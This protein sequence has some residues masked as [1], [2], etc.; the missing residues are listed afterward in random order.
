MRDSSS[1]EKACVSMSSSSSCSACSSARGVAQPGGTIEVHHARRS[2]RASDRTRRAHHLTRHEPDLLVTF[3]AHGRRVS[4]SPGLRLPAGSSHAH[5]PSGWRYCRTRIISPRLRDRHDHHRARMPDDLGVAACRPWAANRLDLDG[6]D[7]PFVDWC[8][9]LWDDRGCSYLLVQS[10]PARQIRPSHRRA[11]SAGS[12]AT[13][14]IR[15]SSRGW[16]KTRRAACR[17]GRSSRCT[18]RMSPATRRC[19]PP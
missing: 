14:S 11:E 15:R 7:A 5:R 17:N 3:P 6:E 1:R 13:N 19:T 8:G 9:S 10:L 2:I 12:R 4:S 18:A 16:V